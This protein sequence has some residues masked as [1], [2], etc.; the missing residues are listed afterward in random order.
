MAESPCGTWRVRSRMA[1]E[2]IPPPRLADAAGGPSR[3]GRVVSVNVAPQGGVPKAAIERTRLGREGVAGDRQ[4]NRKY[5]GGPERAVCLYSL[6]LIEA[7]AGEGHPIG[8][9]S[10]GE[11]L[12]VAG[13]DWSLMVPGAVVRVGEAVVELTS[14]AAPCKTIA[15]AF[16]GGRSIRIGEKGNPGWSRVYGRIGTEGDVWRDAIVELI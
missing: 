6:E 7:L 4:R 5:H 12:T 1:A 9:G 8:P 16:I 3:R 13:I 2:R 14:F 15:G 10:V 11:N